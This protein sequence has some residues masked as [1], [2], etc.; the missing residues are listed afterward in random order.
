MNFEKTMCER[1]GYKYKNVFGNFLYVI[2]HFPYIKEY[3]NEENL[4][5]LEELDLKINT[6]EIEIIEFTL[7]VPL[8]KYLDIDEIIKENEELKEKLNKKLYIKS[9]FTT[10][11]LK[12][13]QQRIDKSIE[14]IKDNACYDE[15]INKCVDDLMYC[16]CDELVE[17][18]KGDNI[19]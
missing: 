12:Q 1:L 17:I 4:K 7:T 6:G 3:I 2:Y 18:L 9:S 19:E 8:Y 10:R 16:N 15:S 14:Y 5:L 11:K 13:L